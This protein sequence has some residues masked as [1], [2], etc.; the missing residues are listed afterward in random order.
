MTRARLPRPAEVAAAARDPRLQRARLAK[1]DD[2]TWRSE[3]S[4]RELDGDAWFP[5]PAEDASAPLAVCAVC[6]VQPDCL[7]WALDIGE[8]E[9][10]AGGTTPRERRAMLVAWRR[11]PSQR[12]PQ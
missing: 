2:A 1:R 10:I 4:C 8:C 3:A 5:L 9:G 11:I 12:V 6:P 7:A